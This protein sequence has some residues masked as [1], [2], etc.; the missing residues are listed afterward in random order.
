MPDRQTAPADSGR[1]S[2]SL[3]RRRALFAALTLA[4]MAGLL[5]LAATAIPPRSFGAVVFL[6]LFAVTLP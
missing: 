2:A 6:G 3:A 4:T 1:A 5:G